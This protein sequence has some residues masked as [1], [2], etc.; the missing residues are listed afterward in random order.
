M[1]FRH[2]SRPS[3]AERPLRDELLS[4]ERLEER[5][6]SLAARF[7]V[8]SPRGRTKRLAPRLRDNAH[9]LRTT[10][11]ALAEDVHRGQFITPPAEWLLDH[12]HLV[13]AEIRAIRQHLPRRYY[14]E[15]PR[16][17]HR[18]WAGHARIYAMA[19]EL[20]RHSDSR[21]DK[22]QLVRFMNSYQSVAPLTI[23][24]LWA[25]P[26][27]LKIALIENLRRLAEEILQARASRIDADDFITAYESGAAAALP[28]SADTGFVVR[29]LQRMR[30]YGIQAST[31]HEAIEGHLHRLN[32]SA[33]DAI[34]GEYQ[35]QAAAQ[36]SIANA[37]TSLR[38]CS[39]LN[40]SDYFEAVSLVEQ[41][42]QRDPAGAYGSMDFLS[43]DRVRQ[44]VEELAAP[45][46]EAQMSVA[47]KAVDSARQVA[48]ALSMTERAAHVGY[49]LVGEG[50]HDLE[51][52]IGYRPKLSKRARRVVLRW[53][54]TFYF[55]LV[56]FITAV[57]AGYGARYVRTHGGS[58]A[59]TV[60]TALLL[61][62]PA[63]EVAIV[64]IQRLVALFIRPRRLLRLNFDQGLPADARTM[65]IVP[66]LLTSVLEVEEL[67]E[68][69]EV[70]ALAN[71]DARLHFAILSD[72]KDAARREMPD[73]AAVLDAASS[74]IESLNRRF[75][76]NGE[77]RFF[78]FHRERLWNARDEVWMGW[79]RKRGKIEEF[80]H[81]LRG[82]KDTSFTVQVG[83]TDILSSVRYCLTLDSD[84]RLPRDAARKM[85]GILAHPLNRPFVDPA[86]R[87]VTRGCRMP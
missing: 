34:R 61:L 5:A 63:S 4:V 22:A 59:E 31:L 8:G 39:T 66:V 82:S 79:E 26:S 36:V 73:D 25:W 75:S 7:T 11:A 62:I 53:P 35:R 41:V 55:S 74:G 19:L 54:A 29:L 46:G 78:L 76:Q 9:V 13:N 58:A 71:S 12:F 80:N 15:L 17:P 16:L 45:T 43:R 56:V 47:L 1:F 84:T 69:L 24:E 48:D 44:A 18:E 64:F 87:R 21:L 23:G 32:V 70:S 33:E 81:L 68:R 86:T 40:W 27:I 37:L 30:E 42:L 65:V 85:V 6:K 67:L 72:F 57:L 2:S 83:T 3:P 51:L 28:P 60:W 38:L 77:S 52:D 10:Y 20:V 14:D 50:R 49:H